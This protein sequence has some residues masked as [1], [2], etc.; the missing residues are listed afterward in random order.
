[1]E[2]LGRAQVEREDVAAR[3]IYRPMQGQGRLVRPQP[4]G[5]TGIEEHEAPDAGLR[6]PA[7]PVPGRALRVFGGQ[8]QG[9]TELADRFPAY[10]EP[11]DL[12]EPLGDVA[13]IRPA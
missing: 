6:E 3:V 7:A 5:R 12:A 8:P 9:L 1:M 4:G 10:L 11:L 2:I 13:I